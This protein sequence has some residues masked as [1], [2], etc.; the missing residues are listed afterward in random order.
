MNPITAQNTRCDGHSF[1]P[2]QWARMDFA[3][4]YI[5]EGWAYPGFTGP[6]TGIS[7]T[8]NIGPYLKV[9]TTE[10]DPGWRTVHR[11]YAV[12]QPGERVFGRRTVRA[13]VWERRAGV[14]YVGYEWEETE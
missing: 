6:V 1:T 2:S 4:A 12:F 5:N 11:V 14:W 13:V 3:R 10:E 7:P 9:S 8:G